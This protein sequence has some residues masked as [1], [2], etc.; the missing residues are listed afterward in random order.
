MQVY[1]NSSAG[2]AYA[3]HCHYRHCCH[4]HHSEQNRGDRS[5]ELKAI[6]KFKDL[7]PPRFSD[8]VSRQ[9][10]VSEEWSQVGFSSGLTLQ[11]LRT[12]ESPD[13]C[14]GG[15]YYYLADMQE[16]TVQPLMNALCI[17]DN[18]KLE[19]Q[20]VTDPYTKERYFEYAHDGKL[21]GRLLIPSNPEN[22][23]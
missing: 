16:K 2:R 10:D 20:E 18:I 1:L 7:T 23:E 21:M 6:S 4:R 5:D 19:Y 11:V 9:D 14:E 8:V 17:A 15:S 3:I 13:G 12:R 22:H